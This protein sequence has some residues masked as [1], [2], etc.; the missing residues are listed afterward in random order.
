MLFDKITLL[1]SNHRHPANPAIP[2]TL[3]KHQFITLIRSSLSPNESQ[4][5]LQT[6]IH[7]ALSELQAQ[8][9]IY[10]GMRN[11]YSITPPTILALD[12]DN[13]IGLRFRGDR[14]YLPLAHQVLK[15]E[16]SH[17]DLSIRPKIGGFN[18]IKNRL[19]QAGIR[20]VTVADSVGY[21]PLPCQP[22]KAVLRSPWPDNPFLLN[23]WQGRGSIHQ[24]IP[25][26]N[27]P[28][29]N[30]WIPLNYQQLEDKSLLQLPTGEYIW[31]QDQAFYE[32]EPDTAM[33]VM[34]HQ[35][36]ETGYPLKIYWDKSQSRLNLQGT[37][38]PSAY[39]QLLWRLSEP[40]SEQYRTRLIESLNHPLVET[41]FQ[42]LGCFLV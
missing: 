13:L 40:D 32:L 25:C 36:K 22:S 38:L 9:E 11:R 39:A 17:D 21:L 42:R 28:Q 24:Y 5:H 2:M 29:K 7:E 23:N 37:S 18:Q 15:T 33:L 31:F 19:N 12:R 16:Q 4:E 8:G 3:S 10:A 6:D 35:D 1:L 27:T 34:F 30:R 20:L 26:S 41:I 14:A